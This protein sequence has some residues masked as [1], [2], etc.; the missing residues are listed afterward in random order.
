MEQGKMKHNLVIKSEWLQTEN[1]YPVFAIT[2]CKNGACAN[3]AMEGCLVLNPD[4]ERETVKFMIDRLFDHL[5]M[6]EK[7]K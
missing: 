5:Q 6:E 4:K 1:G 2:M 3:V 7:N